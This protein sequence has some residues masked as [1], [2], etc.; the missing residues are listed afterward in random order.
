M[1]MPISLIALSLIAPS[2]V[3]EGKCAAA[4]PP[5]PGLRGWAIPAAA[6]TLGK[7]FHLS[8]RAGIPDLTAKERK[9]GGGSAIATLRITAPGTYRIALSNAAWLD[10]V[11]RGTPLESVAHAHGPA[12]SGIRKIVAF[13]LAAGEYQLR[14]SGI[15]ADGV[16]V[17]VARA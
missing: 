10:I 6:P 15:K 12:C 13:R 14:L 17:L 4:A 7:R 11:S 8:A 3:A 16:D 9:R 2:P 1:P 5:P